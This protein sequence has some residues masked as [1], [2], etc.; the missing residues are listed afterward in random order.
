MVIRPCN[1]KTIRKLIIS[2]IIIFIFISN[3]PADNLPDTLGYKR[4]TIKEG[5]RCLICDAPIKVGTGLALLIKGKRI[6]IDLDHLQEF[7]SNKDFY[8]SNL[9]P[10]GALFQESA[11][12][13]KTLRSG[14]FIFG[15][16]IVLS[17][18]MGALSC[19]LAL[20]KGYGPLKWFFIGLF[21]NIFGYI[22]ILLQKSQTE[23]KIPLGWSKIPL[24]STPQRCP[25]CGTSNHPAAEKCI[26]CQHV[27]SPELESEVKRAESQ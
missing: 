25:T 23:K 27:L 26:H 8:L 4:L 13:T 16:W 6:I 19:Q 21:L 3:L 2:I 15:T 20:K 22:L 7:L 1:Q 10:K 11:I 12:L 18:F 5:D 24:T 17:L 14:W 9:Q